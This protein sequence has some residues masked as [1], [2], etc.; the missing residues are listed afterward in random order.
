V[1]DL[2]YIHVYTVETLRL[3]LSDKRWNL[4]LVFV[5]HVKERREMKKE[6]PQPRGFVITG[7]KVEGIGIL[8]E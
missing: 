7:A 3:A 6:L 8:T 5:H 2:V 1:K 4:F